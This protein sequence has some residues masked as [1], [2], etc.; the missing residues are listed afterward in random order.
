MKKIIE[1]VVYMGIMWA[2]TLPVFADTVISNAVTTEANTGGDG[3]ASA[4]VDIYTEV[5]GEV[6]TDI[7]EEKKSTDGS[8]SIEKHVEWKGETDNSYVEVQH[9]G[10]VQVDMESSTSGTDEGSQ[11]N[12]DE[13]K[14]VLDSEIESETSGSLFARV[15]TFF[16]AYV[17]WWL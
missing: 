13:E 6:V 12:E 16:K 3:K 9:E 17:F 5:N 8:V 4:S 14:A 10:N 15:K 11:V 1:T 7:H 2:L